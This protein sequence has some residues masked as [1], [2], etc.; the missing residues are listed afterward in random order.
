MQVPKRPF[1][2]HSEIQNFKI[3]PKRPSVIFQEKT[4]FRKLYQT[5][6]RFFYNET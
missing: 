5:A 2:F 3:V 4:K 6:I 1:V